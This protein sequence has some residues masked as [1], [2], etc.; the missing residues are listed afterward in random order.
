[1]TIQIPKRLAWWVAKHF[2]TVLEEFVQEYV[3][4]MEED[5]KTSTKLRKNK[6]FHDLNDEIEK[7]LWNL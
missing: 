7:K 5:A 2:Q 1:M 3:V 4:E 6:K